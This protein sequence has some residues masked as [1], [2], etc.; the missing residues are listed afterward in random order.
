MNATDFCYDGKM[1]SDFGFII[2]H[3]DGSP[4]VETI[5]TG[6]Q[7]TF[8]TVSRHGGKKYG[9]TSTQY[10]NC[11]T[12]TFHICKNPCQDDMEITSYEYRELV[13]WLNRKKFLPFYF[14]IET[15]E[16]DT[17]YY[18]A[19]F[20]VK[21]ITSDGCLYALELTMETN[22]PFG[23]GNEVVE[24]ITCD[25]DVGSY[26]IDHISDEVGYIY[27]DLTITC[28]QAGEFKM[29]NTTFDSTMLIQNC[30]EQEVITIHGDT[31]IIETS[32]VSHKIY[33]DFNFQFFKLGN[34]YNSRE[35]MIEL[36]QPCTVEIR[37]CPT[38]KDLM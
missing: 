35:N 11:I 34:T 31:Q 38:I 36:Y 9:L 12:S 14:C 26:R 5:D 4:G 29:T 7:I 8:N 13:R 37:Y 6:S 1:L 25:S 30:L 3:F 23:Y 16:A 19:S 33:N 22:S 17:V 32:K 2:C 27:P 21:K 18:D 20:N 28:N 15:M 24:K 10:D